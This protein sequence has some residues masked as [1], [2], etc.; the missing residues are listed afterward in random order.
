MLPSVITSIILSCLAAP[1][2]A[3]SSTSSSSDSLHIQNQHQQSHHDVSRRAIND[4]SATAIIS[5]CVPIAGPMVGCT[6]ARMRRNFTDVNAAA[7][8]AVET[9]GC[10]CGNVFGRGGTVFAFAQACSREV[11]SVDDTVSGT[12]L[13][14]LELITGGVGNN[15]NP[16]VLAIG[17]KNLPIACAAFDRREI[18]LDPQPAAPGAPGV[19]A[20]PA[21]P[22][23]PGVPA[24]PAAPGAPGV[25]AAPAAPGA[26]AA[27]AAPAAPGSPAA[28]AAPAAPGAPAVPSPAAPAAPAAPGAPAAPSPAAPA[29]PASPATVPKAPGSWQPRA[30]SEKEYKELSPYAVDVMKNLQYQFKVNGRVVTPLYVEEESSGARRSF[31]GAS[32]GVVVAL[33]GL[34]LA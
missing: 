10:V 27:P 26:P 2:S 19:P 18:N 31:A 32:L 4:T 13:N 14:I 15:L 24:A 28:P 30:Y 11:L 34:M 17:I 23:V 25:P 21:A 20:A 9:A 33:L 1:S 5:N 8:G 12:I 7:R 29:A 22:G 3:L 6:A 16:A